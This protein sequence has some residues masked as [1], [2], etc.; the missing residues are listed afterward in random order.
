MRGITTPRIPSDE[1]PFFPKVK[2][3]AQKLRKAFD[4]LVKEKGKL[5]KANTKPLPKNKAL[6]LGADI[7]DNSAAATFTIRKSNKK[8]KLRDDLR[9][10]KI[11]KFRKK[12]NF[13]IEL[14]RNRIDSPGELQGITAK[15]LIALRKKAATKRLSSALVSRKA[16]SDTLFSLNRPSSTTKSTIGSFIKRKSGG[17]I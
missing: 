7:T 10:A 4:V 11:S 12:G 1:N 5:L 17:F 16:K 15:G 14:N 8:T 6:N 13:F 9:F 2:T 3:K